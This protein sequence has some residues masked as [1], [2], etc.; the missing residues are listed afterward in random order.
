MLSGNTTSAHSQ[1]TG[2]SGVWLRGHTGWTGTRS[3]GSDRGAK[4][5]RGQESSENG[6]QGR[7]GQ[8]GVVVVAGGL[9]VSPAATMVM[10]IPPPQSGQS[11]WTVLRL[12]SAAGAGDF[13]SR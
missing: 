3:P 12:V 11:S 1:V 8:A 13:R 2:A 7:V 6:A 9:W 4:G 5:E 10:S